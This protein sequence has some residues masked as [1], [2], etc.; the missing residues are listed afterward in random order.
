M[1]VILR[2]QKH[3]GYPAKK[4]EDHPERN[5]ET[6]AS[7]PDIDLRR[8]QLNFHMISPK[9][10]YYSEIQQRIAAAHCRTRKDSVRFVDTRISASPEF[11]EGKSTK[12]I[13]AYHAHACRFIKERIGEQNI[14]SA[15][16]HMDE[17]SPAYAPGICAPNQ[18][19]PSFG[20]GY[21]RQPQTAYRLAGRFLEAYIPALPGT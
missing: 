17:K 18:R 10:K 12:E 4:T 20:Q 21:H 3:Q 13:I 11:F 14:I 7:D 19:Q 15:V 1:Y 5:T 9:G 6:Y 2:F 8:S 16:V